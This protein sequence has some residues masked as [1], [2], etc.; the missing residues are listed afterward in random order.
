MFLREEDQAVGQPQRLCQQ[1]L[2]G[3]KTLLVGYWN[4]RMLRKD[5][6]RNR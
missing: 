5:E 2:S 4:L 1:A 6:V 3:E